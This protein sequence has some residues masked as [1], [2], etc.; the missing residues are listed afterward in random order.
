M[1]ASEL[2]RFAI[3]QELSEDE[4]EGLSEVLEEVPLAQNETLF[5]E[6]DE[7]DYLVLVGT[8]ELRIKQ[9]REMGRAKAGVSL[10]ELSLF[11]FGNRQ[12]SAESVGATTVWL[13]RREEFRRYVEDMP[14]A[15]FRIAEAILSEVAGRSRRAFGGAGR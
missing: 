6:G 15:A 10:G 9:G 1:N 11:T 4:R 14:A 12:V 8:G 2:K 3:L 5:A 7:A 13:L